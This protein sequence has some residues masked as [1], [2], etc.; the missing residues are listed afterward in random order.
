MFYIN[1]CSNAAVELGISAINL[2]DAACAY[3]FA[4]R[5]ESVLNKRRV[6]DNG[7]ALA[8]GSTR[9]SRAAARRA[10]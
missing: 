7:M 4:G 3:R 6:Y 10:L 2:S 8:A 9:V 5:V 1:L